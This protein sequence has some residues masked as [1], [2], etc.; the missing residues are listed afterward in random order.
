MDVIQISTLMWRF[1]TLL[2][3][4]SRALKNGLVS[5]HKGRGVQRGEM[6]GG[7]LT[8]FSATPFAPTFGTTPNILR[9]TKKSQIGAKK[10][11]CFA[12]KKC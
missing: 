8:Y 1:Q 12:R 4:N 5:H 6:R 9:A 10:I 2:K 3:L 7:F 11:A